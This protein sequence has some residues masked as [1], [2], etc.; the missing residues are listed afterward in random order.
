MT[1]EALFREK[2]LKDF[3]LFAKDYFRFIQFEDIKEEID[4]CCRNELG[5]Y[6]KS[7]R[8]FNNL[9]KVFDKYNFICE[10]PSLLTKDDQR[11]MF[12]MK[13][14]LNNHSGVNFGYV[15]YRKQHL[16]DEIVKYYEFAIQRNMNILALKAD[17][18]LEIERML[19]KIHNLENTNEFRMNQFFTIEK[20]KQQR[21]AWAK[22]RTLCSCGKEY[23]NGDKK[24]HLKTKFHQNS[25]L[26]PEQNIL[27]GKG[28]NIS[29]H[30]DEL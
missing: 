1:Y 26:L 16:Q 21:K 4:N 12:E 17:I 3:P 13:K 14:Y 9:K 29:L 5:D 18:F 15:K 19:E 24:A 8:T 20:A 25:L 10:N 11:N 7:N 23:S 6:Q 30:I 22:K 28:E 27:F 2:A